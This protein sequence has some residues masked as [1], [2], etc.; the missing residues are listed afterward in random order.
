LGTG[1]F[2]RLR[3]GIGRPP[4]GVDPTEFVL[5]RFTPEERQAIDP[6]IARAVEA[7]MVAARQGLAAAMNQFNRRAGAE[8]PV[9]P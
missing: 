1:A 5:Q 9:A 4:A 8:S 2:P 7:V 6:A 3:I